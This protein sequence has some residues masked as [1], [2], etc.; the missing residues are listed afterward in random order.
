MESLAFVVAII[1]LGA[2]ALA[3]SSAIVAIV[4]PQRTWARV[5]G[6]VIALPTIAVGVWLWWVTDTLVARA[7]SAG[8]MLVGGTA[9]A[10]SV[11]EG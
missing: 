6:A 7:W 8:I 1:F 10:R 2:F 3:L 11:R 4:N 9:L 5:L